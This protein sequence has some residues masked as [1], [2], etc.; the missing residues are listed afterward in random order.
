MTS[1]DD[2][3]FLKNNKS[4]GGRCAQNSPEVSGT[5]A[6]PSP[7]KLTAQKKPWKAT[8][9]TGCGAEPNPCGEDW[10][11]FGAKD[12]VQEATST[13]FFFI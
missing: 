6:C 2:S 1:K 4:W 12:G 13:D 10:L 7:K 11:Y 3:I 9:A 5:F 8:K